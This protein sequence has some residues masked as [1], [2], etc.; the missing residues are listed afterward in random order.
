MRSAV[1]GALDINISPAGLPEEIVAFDYGGFP[2]VVAKIDEIEANNT[3]VLKLHAGDAITGDTFYIAFEGEADA[4]LMNEVCFD[5]F[6]VGNHEFDD[7]D[8]GLASFLDFLEGGDCTTT[9]P[10]LGANVVPG[11]SSPLVDRLAPYT[12]A[13]VGGQSVGII[14]INTADK[15]KNSSNP[16]EDTTF[17]DEIETAQENIDELTAMGV[18]KIIILSH[19]GYDNELDM[20]ANLS[21][22]DIIVGGDSH[23][24]LGSGYADLG[25]SPEGEYPTVAQNADGDDVCVV[26]AWQFSAVVGELDVEF[27]QNGVVD[28]CGGTPHLLLSEASV[29]AGSEAAAM[30]FD[31]ANPLVSIIAPEANAQALLA[32]FETE[33]DAEF[34]EVV[35]AASEDLCYERV[36]GQGRSSLVGCEAAATIA[37]GGDTPQLVARAFREFVKDIDG[38]TPDISIQNAGGV[39]IDIPAGDITLET[40]FNLLPF[41]NTMVILSMT[42]QEVVDVLN[43]AVADGFGSSGAYPYAAG[44]RFDADLNQADGSR[45]FNVEV[46]GADGATY[47]AID[48]TATYTVVTNSFAAGGGDGYDT[49]EAVSDRGDAFDTQT[50]YV[51]PFIDFL[52]ENPSL[53]KPTTAEYSTQSFVPEATP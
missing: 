22:V 12:I 38:S 52:E 53:S 5:A 17:T 51:Q 36:P 31:D 9:T 11:A 19:F 13:E 27:D 44:L 35:G 30:A 24:L 3:N 18:N 43:E 34:S 21:G 46:L 48:L 28:S 39:R 37:N 45:I 7:G 23:S 40:A 33:I 49:F 41:D 32:D 4:D 42:G 26:Q 50:R 16:D 1:F 15:T 20:A 8:A 25:L 10:V 29:P 47:E 6:V 14:G 2:R